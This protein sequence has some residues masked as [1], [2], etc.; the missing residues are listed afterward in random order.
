MFQGAMLG[1]HD[2]QDESTIYLLQGRVQLR[3]GE[4]PWIARTGALLIVP[5][6]RHSL[7]ALEDSA[8]LITIAKLAS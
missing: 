5:Q 3:V 1:E 2:N 6:A 7:E 4:E 8:L